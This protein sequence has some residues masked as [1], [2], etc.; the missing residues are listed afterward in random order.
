M[1]SP[2]VRAKEVRR[3]YHGRWGQ[4]V[5]IL[6]PHEEDRSAPRPTLRR[7]SRGAPANDSP[8]SSPA[9][10]LPL[11]EPESPRSAPLREKNNADPTTARSKSRSPPNPNRS[12]KAAKPQSRRALLPLHLG[13][14]ARPSPRRAEARRP[15]HHREPKSRA[16]PTPPRVTGRDAQCAERPA[17]TTGAQPRAPPPPPGHLL[18]AGLDPPRSGRRRRAIDERGA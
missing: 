16:P 3:G 11:L 10:C 13:G 9:P 5:A 7:A 17:P 14:L 8:P 1:R 12:R 2:F 18:V 6:A 4:S 15:H